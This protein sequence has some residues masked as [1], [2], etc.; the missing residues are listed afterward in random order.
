MK[1]LLDTQVVLWLSTATRSI[2]CS[3][4]RRASKVRRS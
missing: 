1:L 2:V 3:S 4:L